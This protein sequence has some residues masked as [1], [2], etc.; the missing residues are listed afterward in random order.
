MTFE[1]FVEHNINK[2]GETYGK[3]TFEDI[4]RLLGES[5]INLEKGIYDKTYKKVE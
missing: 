4:K 2:Q 1:Q 5:H 3:Y